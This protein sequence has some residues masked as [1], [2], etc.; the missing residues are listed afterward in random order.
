MRTREPSC[1]SLSRRSIARATRF[2]VDETVRH[3]RS[4]RLSKLAEV[5]ER[6]GK[7]E[8]SVKYLTGAIQLNKEMLRVAPSKDGLRQLLDCRRNLAWLQYGRGERDQ[9]RSLVADNVLLLENLPPEVLGFT[10]P[11]NCF[12]AHIDSQ[13]LDEGAASVTKSDRK[14]P[15]AP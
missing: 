11:V 7:P 1:W 3:L 6:V 4:D 15:V 9:A 12:V 2:P 10:T 5:S 8:D 14:S 13:L